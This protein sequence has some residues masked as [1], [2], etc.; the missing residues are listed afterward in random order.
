MTPAESDKRKWRPWSPQ[1]IK[2]IL[3]SLSFEQ[4]KN[5]PTCIGGFLYCETF[6][7]A[8]FFIKRDFFLEAELACNT[9]RLAA[10][11]AA[12]W[13]ARILVVAS[14]FLPSVTRDLVSLNRALTFFLMLA[15]CAAR[16]RLLRSSL[17]AACLFGIDVANHRGNYRMRQ[18]C[19]E[20]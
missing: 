10:L 1:T 7:F 12:C 5:P 8:S 20:P 6:Y 2:E 15:L 9:P 18:V 13:K 17:M 4:Y 14:S 19:E 11:S 16:L 3:P